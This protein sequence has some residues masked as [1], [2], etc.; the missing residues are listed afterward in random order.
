MPS[1]VLTR[2]L[3]WL[4]DE[5]SDAIMVCDTENYDILYLNHVACEMCGKS[6]KE[7]GGKKCYEFLWGNTEPCSHCVP[8]DRMEKTY[9]EHE[10]L[11]AVKGK[12]YIIKGKLTEWGGKTARIQFI[13]DNTGKAMAAKQLA[14]VSAD[15]KRLLDLMPGGIFRYK[16]KEDDTFDFVSE[17]MLK[18]LGYS[19]EEFRKKFHNRFSNMVWHEDRARIL[20]EIDDQIAVRDSDECDY[21]IEKGDGFLCWVHDIGRLVKDT[22]GQ[23]WFYVAIMDITREHRITEKLEE[24]RKKLEIALSHSKL[25]YWEHDLRT[26]VAVNGVKGADLG[27]AEVTPNYSRFLIESGIV[28]ADYIELYKA[29]QQLLYGG[30]KSVEYEIPLHLPNGGQSWWHICCTNLF[31]ASGKPIKTIGTA[32]NIDRLKEYEHSI[33]KNKTNLGGQHEEQKSHAHCR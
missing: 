1:P 30:A 12:H 16:A 24:E 8:L 3:D 5:T 22:T 27:F 17:N 26:D 6:R 11:D 13:Q 28:P 9:C 10:V 19:S 29:K 20:K 21:R 32:E 7:M 23:A 25:Q 14:D 4:L 18:M 2:N 31:D 15:R 33:S